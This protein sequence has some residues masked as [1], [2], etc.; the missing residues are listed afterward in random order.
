MENH[1]RLKILD[2]TEQISSNISNEKRK[3]IEVYSDPRNK[4]T[5]SLF[6]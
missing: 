2:D 3:I 6:G 1:T 5:K 4:I